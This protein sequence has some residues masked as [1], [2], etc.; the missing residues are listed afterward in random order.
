MSIIF[1]RYHYHA[2]P[3]PKKLSHTIKPARDLLFV[4][5]ISNLGTVPIFSPIQN[6]V[7]KNRKN[8]NCIFQRI[9][10][11]QIFELEGVAPGR[12]RCRH[13]KW[14]SWIAK[15][16]LMTSSSWMASRWRH[17]I[18][19]CDVILLEK[20]TRT[21]QTTYNCILWSLISV[22]NKN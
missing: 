11:K 17:Q 14:C 21:V 16:L 7:Q 5:Y 22:D 4:I 6:L 19:W 15:T 10:L 20:V 3:K 2:H 12:G 8:V 18:T 9:D 13:P 1:E